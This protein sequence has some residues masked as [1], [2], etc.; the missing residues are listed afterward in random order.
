[1]VEI[2]AYDTEGGRYFC[3]FFARNKKTAIR[4]FKR[5]FKRSGRKVENVTIEKVEKIELPK[6]KAV[7]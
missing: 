5:Q 6:V 1:M 2:V 3:T 7:G 4:F